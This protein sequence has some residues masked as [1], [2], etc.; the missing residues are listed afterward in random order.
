M[1]QAGQEAADAITRALA[2]GKRGGK[3]YK[4]K[5]V[6]KRASS[7]IKGLVG[8][9]KSGGITKGGL[10]SKAFGAFSSG[11]GGVGAG[12]PGGGT[13]IST[14]LF[15]AHSTMLHIAGDL[16]AIDTASA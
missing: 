3:P 5:F 1:P 9:P 12:V 2:A 7:A 8:R 10:G 11:L 4:L 16:S 14:A 6:V 15:E 13:N